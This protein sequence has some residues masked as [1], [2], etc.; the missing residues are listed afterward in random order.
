VLRRGAERPARPLAGALPVH[1]FARGHLAGQPPPARGL[2][3]AAAAS[4]A[5]G[6]LPGAAG[7]SPTCL[8]I[9]CTVDWTSDDADEYLD[10]TLSLEQGHLKYGPETVEARL[11]GHAT[12]L[13][14]GN[15]AAFKVKFPKANRL[16]GLKSIT[17]NNM[18]QGKSMVHEAL[19]YSF[20]EPIDP[21]SILSGWDGNAVDVVVRLNNGSLFQADSVLVYDTANATQLNLGTVA[22]GDDGYVTT[23]RTFGATGTKSRMVLAGNTIAVTLGIASGS[24]TSPLLAATMTWTPTSSAYDRAANAMSTAARS[25]AGALDKEF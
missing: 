3:L 21:G 2:H 5:V 24:V 17:L 9:H 20:S 10:A 15:K 23:S 25:E 12:F 4:R 7:R 1:R 22:L 18:V 13:P 14:L 8:N 16:L 11:K 19:G 6:R